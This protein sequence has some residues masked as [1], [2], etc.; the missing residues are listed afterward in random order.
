MNNSAKLNQIEQCLED[1]KK[2]PVKFLTE[3]QNN[4]REMRAESGLSVAEVSEKIGYSEEE[5]S[6]QENGSAPFNMKVI[7]ALSLFYDGFN[8]N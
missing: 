7:V 6:G 3:L 4:L 1:I 2:D 8:K 5:I